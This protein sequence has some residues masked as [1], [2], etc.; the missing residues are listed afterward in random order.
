MARLCFEKA[1]DMYNEK[2]ARAASLQ[3][4]AISISSSS[5]Q[6]AKNYL[7]E[8]ADMFEGI[9][10][11]EY[12]ANCFFEMRSYE[13]AGICFFFFFSFLTRLYQFDYIFFISGTV[14]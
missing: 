12:A 1:G 9:G 4:L 5:P 11:A 6:M 7:S 8:A 10:K 13:R 3:A 14:I 2:F